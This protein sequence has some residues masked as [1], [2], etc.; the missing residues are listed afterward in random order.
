MHIQRRADLQKI[1]RDMLP[2]LL[3]NG[4]KAAYVQEPT[5]WFL[6]IVQI[7]RSLLKEALSSWSH[8]VRRNPLNE[9]KKMLVKDCK[10]SPAEAQM[11]AQMVIKAR[12]R[13]MV[14]QS[15]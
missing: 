15:L 8:L 6:A 14:P 3:G 7:L 2:D 1:L 12:E 5:T 13:G 11:L 9:W 4:C 10:L